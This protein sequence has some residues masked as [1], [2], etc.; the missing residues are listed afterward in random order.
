MLFA[1]LIASLQ[2]GAGLGAEKVSDHPGKATAAASRTEV[3][4]AGEEWLPIQWE[5]A[6]IVKGSALDFSPFMDAPAG[7]WGPAVCR[8]G[9][10][11]FNDAPHKAARIYGVVVGHGLPFLDKERCERFADYLAS[12]GYNGVRLHNYTFVKGVMKDVGAAEFTPESLDQLDYL[13]F[14]LKQRGIYYTFPLN[15]WG[16]FKAGDVRD[17]PEFRD[18]PFRFESNGL[19]PISADLQQWFKDYS[20]HLLCHTNPY[21]GIAIKDDPALLSIELTNENSLLAVLGHFPDL[22]PIYRRMCGEWLKTKTSREP[23]AEEVDRELPRYAM[24]LQ[25]EFYLG[26]RQFL[27]QL[28]V[29]QPLTDVNVRDNLAYALPRS[30][31]D[32]V[33]IHAY[34]A[35][36]QS[37]PGQRRGEHAYRQ[38]WS[39]PNSVGWSYF[40]GPVACRLFGKPFASSEFNGCYPC[41]YWGYTGPVEA[42]LAAEQDWSLIARCGLAA[43]P[44]RFFQPVGCNRIDTSA[45]PLMMLSERIGS[46][47]F[48]QGE[49]QPLAVKLPLILTPEYLL[50]KL[51]IKGGPKCPTSY[52]QLAFRYQ[53]GTILLDGTENL[54][55]YPC[56]IAPPDM[57][58]PETL[59][60]K[61]VLRADARL[62]EALEKECP[63][64][65][66]IVQPRLELDQGRGS[67]QI[68][69]A[70]SETFLLPASVDSA[71]GRCV[72]LTGNETSAVCFAASLD[73]RPLAESSRVVVLYLTDL[74][75]SG[76][77]VEY[78]TAP[79]H[80]V[81]TRKPGGLPQLVRQGKI[82][83]TFARK[84]HALPKIWA[85]RYDGSRS[86]AVEPRPAADGFVFEVQAVTDPET[87][88]A[89]EL[90]W[91]P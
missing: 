40:L 65:D 47:L 42:A 73:R 43:D 12:C 69:T 8:D 27:R 17:V 49:L 60:G 59:K 15:A 85:L 46:V 64:R 18:R 33:D 62:E 74:K 54:N 79:K 81:I 72:S 25:K 83:L 16:F 1:L 14:C 76:A 3:F 71:A 45:S 7:K 10:F 23:T 77:E 56:L 29:R 90:V 55:G 48:S 50:E 53:L 61:K 82:Q 34:W 20:R 38:T 26:M 13:F 66:Q 75:C 88:C 68:V 67:A 39:N 28:G 80:S 11:V 30:E 36:Y 84:G 37:L 2:A 32:Y 5:A 22:V 87:F 70:R 6:K 52:S 63:A 44:K 51:D 57:K 4:R 89:Y 35:L 24:R 31:L 9:R 78:E 41:P 91:R 21:T 19:L 58:L 86:V